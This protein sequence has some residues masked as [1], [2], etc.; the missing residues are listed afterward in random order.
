MGNALSIAVGEASVS[1][2]D[3]VDVRCCK[4]VQCYF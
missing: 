3:S 2:I 1:E 4:G